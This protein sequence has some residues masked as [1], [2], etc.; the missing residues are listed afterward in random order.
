MEREETAR[1]NSQGRMTGRVFILPFKFLH[2]FLPKNLTGL[3]GPGAAYHLISPLF[4]SE[5]VLPS[6]NVY[7]GDDTASVFAHGRNE[8]VVA[9][10]FLQHLGQATEVA[11]WKVLRL[12]QVQDHTRGTGF[13]GKVVQI[14][15]GR[16]VRKP[17]G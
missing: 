15:E 7:L 6:W 5:H 16:S 9:S 1:K 2:L 11:V 14:P 10:H 3:A 4:L 13:G 12:P 8:A 17:P